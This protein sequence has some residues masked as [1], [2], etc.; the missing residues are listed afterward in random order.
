MFFVFPCGAFPEFFFCRQNL[1]LPPFIQWDLAR[2]TLTF[3]AIIQLEAKRA[4][5]SWSS[6][7]NIYLTRKSVQ[8]TPILYS[9]CMYCY[10]WFSTSLWLNSSYLVHNIL[11]L[12]ARK[13]ILECA[14]CE[15][16]PT[17]NLSRFQ[18]SVPVPP[19]NS[20]LVRTYLAAGGFIW[21]L[22]QLLT[23]E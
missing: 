6:P 10:L 5:L 14:A 21:C 11:R 23:L 18:M 12:N 20:S 19:A 16:Q 15:T 9:P 13:G 8:Y 17:L 4:S 2:N 7:S 1:M 22:W 3:I